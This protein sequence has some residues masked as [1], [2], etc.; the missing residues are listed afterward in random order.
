M[1]SATGLTTVQDSGDVTCAIGAG[2]F[3]IGDV[4]PHGISDNVNFWGAQ[5]WKN[6]DMSG[7]VSNGVASFKGFADQ[8][9]TCGQTWTS[10]PGNSS[11]PPDTIP[12]FVAVIVTDTVLKQGPNISGT[13]K[14]I[15]L[16]HQDGGYGPAPGHRGNGPVV[17]VF[18]TAP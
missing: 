12:Q 11:K 16:V 6:N 4:E 7:F 15:V 5:W 1:A 3:V 18:C 10:L 9:G 14:Q 8:A 2:L 13:I 17:S